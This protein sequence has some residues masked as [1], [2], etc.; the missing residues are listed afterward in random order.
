M[1][2]AHFCPSR[3][4]DFNYFGDN[5]KMNAI[6]SQSS[7]FETR[8]FIVADTVVF[9]KQGT[10]LTDIQKIVLRGAW[11]GYT[12]EEIADREGYSE[13]YL[14]RDV[15]PRLWKILSEA[16][17]EK[18]SKKN[19]RTAL[20]RRLT[21]ANPSHNQQLDMDSCQDWGEAVDVHTFYG[22]TQELATLQ[23][24]IVQ[25][26]CPLVAL[27][28]MGGIGKTTLSIKL[29]Q[30]LQSDFKYIIWRS[31]RHA[32]PIRELLE[33]IIYFLSNQQEKDLPETTNGRISLL[34]KYFRKS[35]CL[36]I[37]DGAESILNYD[38]KDTHYQE[39]DEEYGRL[40]KYIGETYHQ[41]CLLLTSREKPKEVAIREGEEL[42]TR[43]LRLIGL[44]ELEGQYILKGKGIYGSEGDLKKIIQ[45]YGGNPLLLNMVSTTIQNIFD[46]SASDF[47][48]QEIIVFNDVKDFFDNQFNR[49]QP[50]EKELMYCL[51][52]EREPVSFQKLK[53]D[54]GLKV[55]SLELAEA[56]ESLRRRS[57]VEKNQGL[58]TLQ[59]VLMEYTTARLLKEICQEIRT[60]QISLLKSSKLLKLIV[61]NYVRTTQS[62]IFFRMVLDQ[63]LL[64]LG[65]KKNVESQLDTILSTLQHESFKLEDTTDDIISLIHRMQANLSSYK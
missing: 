58:F 40:I 27:V 2:S 45:I 43:S 33:E 39:E 11:Q 32:P 31:L 15:G 54:F 9:N 55:Q 8:E 22:R 50:I 64:E 1:M 19:F 13:K 48:K 6:N 63:L 34:L 23:Q 52:I 3:A 18:V 25:D 7:T 51:A 37:L 44:D 29:A 53:N 4:K 47:L 56:L 14:K 57:L 28:G 62:N 59:I 20:E 60:Q 38:R 41:S 24:W 10:H 49:L 61:K 17:G 26:R 21:L 65:S 36:L 46:S 35:P 5:Y 30:Q 16:L 12:Y 42:P